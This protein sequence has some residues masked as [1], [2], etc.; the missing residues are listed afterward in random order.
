MTVSRFLTLG[1]LYNQRLERYA[2][3][4]LARVDTE[5]ITCRAHIEKELGSRNVR[6]LSRVELG[7]YRDR[8]ANE[9]TLQPSGRVLVLLSRVFNWGVDEGLIEFNPV[10]RLRKPRP[11]VR[12]R[13]LSQSNIAVFWNVLS[14]MDITD[15][16]ARR[17]PALDTHARS[18]GWNTVSVG[19]DVKRRETC[20]PA[21]PARGARHW[22]S[23]PHCSK[24]ACLKMKAVRHRRANWIG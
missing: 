1:N 14:K 3:P 8:V 10:A 13:V 9:K 12:D 24:R 15:R 6:E 20:E 19:V 5:E 21:S 18:S 4:N 22:R 16:R 23:W 11:G 2:R 17:I 7:A